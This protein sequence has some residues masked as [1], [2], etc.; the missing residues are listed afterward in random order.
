MKIC[1]KCARSFADGFTYCPNDAAALDKYDL[2]AHLH[3]KPELQ[4]LLKHES[5]AARLRRELR[6]AMEELRRNPRGYLTSLLRGEGSPRRRKRLLQAGAATAVISYASIAILAMLIS[7]W[8]APASPLKVEAGPEDL[9]KINGYKFVFIAAK[10]ATEAAK[11]ASS[12]SLGGSLTKAQRPSGGGGQQNG[13]PARN[14]APPQAAPIQLLKPNL[15]PPPIDPS[16]PT[17][18]TI[19]ADPASLL[20]IKAP[21]GLIGSP[22]NNDS[23]GDG[24]GT[25]IGPGR[26]PGYG[27]GE[28]SNTGDGPNKRGGGVTTG[29][30]PGPLRMTAN[31]RPTILYKERAPYTEDARQNR[32][33]G[34]VVLNVTFGADARIHDIGVVRGLPHGLTEKAIEAAK[35]SRFT[36]AIRDGK[37]VGVRGYI[38]FNF[39]LY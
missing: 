27:P 32:V 30:G 8:T 22:Y 35:R 10:P 2:R 9:E 16:L 11:K 6:S 15:D 14:G 33:Q 31:L 21:L 23:L 13:A 39:A 5:L 24:P 19:V 20:K 34:I 37:P 17:A 18:M 7:L 36:P 38:E 29:A 12:G 28:D 4:F 3:S 1:P 25:G 26:G